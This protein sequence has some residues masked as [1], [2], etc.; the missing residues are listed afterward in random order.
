MLT[1][2]LVFPPPLLSYLL[3]FDVQA[4]DTGTMLQQPMLEQPM[5]KGFISHGIREPLTTRI[6]G[7]LRAYPDSTQIARELLQN[8]DDA[9]STVQWYLLDHR[10]HVKHA[11]RS[12]GSNLDS[13]PSKDTSLRLFHEDLGEYMGPALLSGSDSVFEEKDFQ[14]LKNLASSVKRADESKIGQMGIGFNSIYHLTDCPSFISGDQ[15]MIIEPHERIFN[16]ERFHLSEGAVR[17]SFL[18]PSQGLHEYPDQLKTFSVLED[19]DFSK[20]YKGTIFRFPLRTPEQAKTSSLTKYPRT[21][22]EVLEMLNELKNEALKALL[23]L[24]HVQKIVIYERRE[25]Q[26][27]PTKLFEIEIVNSAEVAAQRSQLI[28]NFKRHVRLC[29]SIDEAEVLECSTR[30]I[31]KMTYED[32]RTTEETWQ[33]TTR[34]GNIGKTRASMLEASHGDVNIADHKLIPWVGIAAPSDPDFKMDSSGLFC[35]LPVGDIQLPFPVHVN[36]HFAVEQSRRDIWTNIDKKIKTQ[37]SAGIE[38]LW[39]VHLF[40]KQIPEAYALFLE[41]IGLDHGANYELWPTYCGDGVGRDAVWKDVLKSTLRAALSSDR[42]VFFCGPKPDGNIHVEPY[43]KVYI[44]GRDIDAFPLLKKALRIVVDL[45][46]D[47]PDVILAELPDAVESLELTFRTLTPALVISILH[48]TKKQ[49]SSTADAAT[50]VEMVKYCLQDDKS[51]SLVGLPLLPLAGGSWVEFSRKQSRERFRVSVEVF[52]T[53]SVSNGGLVD[54]E[55]EGYPFDDIELGCRSGS[56]NGSKSKMYWSTMKPSSVAERIRSAYHQLFYQ[57]NV[58]PDGR[59]CQISEQFPM[60]KW[61]TD[62]WNMVNS[63]PN[64]VDQKELLSGLDG[65]HLIPINRDSLAPLS[66]DRSVLYLNPGTSKDYQVSQKALEVLDHRFDCKVLRKLPMNS[67]SPLHGYLVDVSVGPRVLGLLSNVNRGCFEQLTPTDCENL[68]QYLTIC[69]SPRASLDSQQRQVLRHLPVFESYQETRL[70]P[71]DTPSSSMQWSVAQGYCHSSQPWIPSSVNLLAEDQPM[72][73]HIRYLLEIPFLTKAEF[74]RLLVSELKERPE[75]EWDPILSELLLGYYEHQKKVDFA[76]L[77]RPL[78]F[79]QVKTSTSEM[80]SSIRIKPRFVADPALSMFFMDDEAVF[81][82]GIYA[83]PAFRGPLEELGMKLAFNSTFVEERMSSLFSATSS[84]QGDTHKKASLALYDRLNSMFSKEFLTKDILSMMSSLPWLYAGKSERC[85]PSDCRPKEDGCLVR[86]Q[87]SISEFS[88]SNTLLRKHMG[89][90]TPPPLE[91][92]LAHFSSLLDQAS[93]TGGS[94]IQLANQD[95]SSIYKYLAL[96]VQNPVSLAAIEKVL[97]NRPWILVSGTLYT[98]DR[99]A[100]KLDNNLRPQFAQVASSSLDDLF[101]ALGVRESISQRDIEAILA[102]IRS[103][104]DNTERL[105]N[106]D[107]DLVRR[108]L[109]ALAH[110]KSKRLTSDLPVLTK[111]GYLKRAAD[112]VYDDRASRRGG[113]DDD[114]LPY[115]FLDDD[116]SKTVA[117]CLQIDM[118]S[119]RAWEECK[120]TT[121]EPFFQ[122][123]DIVDRIKGILND[124][125]PSGIFIEYLQNASDAGATK[126][127]VM[128]DTRTYDKA[129]V[130]SERMGAWQGPALLFYNDAKFSEEN[131]SALCKLGV[132]NKREDTSK[133][134]RH[135]LGFNSAYHF[136]DVPSL[137]SGDSLVIFDPH[138]ANL[139]RSRDNYGKLIAQRGHRYDIRKLTTETLVDQFQP[140][141]G[142]FGFDMESH[143]NGT[144]FRIPLRLKGAPMVGKTGF[145]GEDWTPSQIQRMFISWIEDA[146]VGMLFLRNIKSIELSDGTSP[147]V[148]VTK[149]DCANEPAVQFLTA[150]LPSHASQVSIVDIT[151]TSTGL[152]NITNAVSSRWLVYTEDAL[153]A[154]TPQDIRSLVQTQHWSTQSGVAIPLGDDRAIK[155]CRGRLMV[156]LPTPIETKLPFHMHGG[157]ALT[158][159]RKTLA[160]G[161]EAGDPKTVWNTYL[162]DTCLPLTAL[163]AYR[164]LL[165]WSFRPAPLGGPQ[166]HEL[167]TA[168]PNFYKRWPLKANDGFAT[169]LSAFFQHAYTSPV[170][171]CRGHPSELPIEAVAGKNTT[172]RGHIISESVETRVFSW[173]REAGR[174]I[175][176]TPTDLQTCLMREWGH[177]AS[178]PFKQIDCNL[179]RKRLR[180][181]PD[182]IPRQM[183]SLKDKQ[184]ILEEIF[185]PMDNS[186]IVAE[187]SLLG[188]CVVP[189]LSGEWKPLRPSPI[190][191]IATAE[192]RE[193]VEGKELLV[194]SD[195]FDSAV[196]QRVKNALV[197]DPAY[198]IEEIRLGTFASIFLSENPHGVSE[199]KLEKVWAYLNKFDDITP[200]YELPIVKTTTGDVVT[201][202]KAAE[203]LE[204]STAILQDKPIHIMAEFFCRMGVTMFNASQHQSHLYLRRLQVDYSERRALELIAKNWSTH[205]SSFVISAEE[206]GFLREMISSQHRYCNASVLS[207]LGGLPIWRTY[208]PPGVPL[209]S[210]IGFFYMTDHESL[211]NLGHHPTILHEVGSMIP[212]DRMGAT[213]I[214]AASILRERIMPKFASNELQCTGATKSAYL[215]LCRSLMATASYSNIRENALAKQVLN[216]AQCFLSRDGS[217][218]TLAQMF[219]PG[220]DLTETIFV[221]EQ[222]RFPDSDLYT[223]LDGRFSHG[224]R[225]LMT[226]AVEDCATF[227]LNEIANGSAAADQILSRATHLVR[228]IYGNPGSTNW[229]DP[230]WTFVPREMTPEYPYNQHAPALPHYMS[231]STLCY[232]TER[233]YLWT[234]RGFFPQDLVPSAR[235]R[236]QFSNIGRHTWRE[237]CQHLEVLVKNIAPTMSTTERQLTFKATIF[238]IYKAF[239][240]RGSEKPTASDIIKQSLREIMTVPYILNGDD[241]DPTKAE[242]WVWPQDLVFGID[243][244]IGAHQQAHRSLLKFRNFLVSVGANEM[245]HIAGQV[246]VRSKRNIGELENRITTYFET[247]DEKNGFM[248]VKFVFEGGKSILAH[249]VV[250]A[251]MNEEVIRQL[252][253]SWALSARRDPSNPAIDIIQKGDDYITFWG[254]LYFLYTDELIGTNGPPTLSAAIKPFKE[255]DAE[256]QLS[257]RVEYLVALQH[258]ADVYRTDRLKGLIAQE[259]MLPGKVM[260]SNVFDIREHAELNRDPSVVKYCNQFIEVKENASL[261]EKYLEDE[262]VSVQAKLV[263]LDQY[264]GDENAQDVTEEVDQLE[265]GVEEVAAREALRIELEDLE[266]Y[267]SELKMKR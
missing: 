251:S 83:K 183:K 190:Y 100:F 130:L 240:D 264:L 9:G 228:Y 109:T 206:A 19:I 132:G 42:P 104:Y 41:N 235:F 23:F 171:P 262:V 38:S 6:A 22:E 209:R 114:Q 188:L 225:R 62:F 144:I 75:S 76:P 118:F 155:S 86:S 202:A 172:L 55:V 56:K 257:E 101:L 11:R 212:F 68:R 194:N 24:K 40:D 126:F 59:V 147:M 31:Y 44:A 196:L 28:D 224:I 149:H 4:K 17:G 146:K 148:S 61:L 254:L 87:M 173:L 123:E 218:Q 98:V 79:V 258:L 54:V 45:A 136:T 175:A 120:D 198:G 47:V 243:H 178:R 195:L 227:V 27:K 176:E 115:T 165:T 215:A 131:F 239:E 12:A 177:D 8:S 250:L 2:L 73:H 72:K 192:A 129:K 142:V 141:K 255:Q 36:G 197:K 186:S 145:G 18:N 187:E 242:S 81:P 157:F 64:A 191:Y 134:G 128:L 110:M 163:Q 249:K 211:E 168:I 214:Q 180:Q 65:I 57:N 66:K 124:Y 116:I 90:T 263:A 204:I 107:A 67:L 96:K 248:D 160:G 237:Y 122:Q 184:W 236:Q 85:R 200:A 205:A 238:K 179:L 30:P 213:S 143:F 217:F 25:D 167:N 169:F 39:N 150:S 105:S 229:M 139:P 113:S 193:L 230:K 117:Q 37:S 60:N 246:T 3:S 91:K 5:R 119:V 92:V 140:Y 259:L 137:V 181:D 232:P 133:V 15:L 256:D 260:Y 135:G 265:G 156:H 253:G 247:Q 70:V 58:V 33:V 153:P 102:T 203:G 99:V 222:H 32:G 266:G 241:M 63:F 208:G 233:D 170:F 201:V 50:R 185:R 71:L 161:S 78:P 95:V 48:D 159:N 219:V 77:L 89:W 106:K 46:E 35:F 52:R 244:K 216:H 151:S 7:I 1:M 14:S 49:W 152:G 94:T 80:A 154:N 74:L 221:N 138:M 125:D 69:L 88:P 20:P 245:K 162:L 166:V 174:S 207:T 267:L 21:P 158:T 108:L 16:G 121:F 29:D 13:D 10:D 189:L 43:S 97:S 223:I 210:A 26:D 112:V 261:I 234:Q 82:S 231:F 103:N 53:L 127:S 164:Q 34:I 93:I 111:G 51:V 252:T 220:E 182:F 199:D 84:G 226:G